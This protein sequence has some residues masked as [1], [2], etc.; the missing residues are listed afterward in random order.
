MPARRRPNRRRTCRGQAANRNCRR[1]QNNVTPLDVNAGNDEVGVVANNENNVVADVV[2]NDAPV[3]GDLEFAGVAER[4]ANV[5]LGGG[6]ALEG[7]VVNN[8]RVVDVAARADDR[9]NDPKIRIL[10]MSLMT[11]LVVR[12]TG[13]ISASVSVFV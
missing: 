6:L 5:N 2:A 10:V 9:V 12:D 1:C 7:P 13:T 11:Q 3:E 4:V 8:A